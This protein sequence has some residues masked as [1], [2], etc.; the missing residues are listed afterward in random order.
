MPGETQVEVL[1]GSHSQT[2]DVIVKKAI[3]I[4]YIIDELNAYQLM[5]NSGADATAIGK[6]MVEYQWTPTSNMR[7]WR[8]GK[9]FYANQT[10]TGIPYSQ[11][12]N[13]VDKSGFASAMNQPDFYDDYTRFSIIMP[14]YGNDCPGFVSFCWGISRKTTS[15]FVNGI[16][17]GT[18]TKVGTY[19]ADNPTLTSLKTS[20]RNL[21]PGNAVVKSGH[22]FLIASNDRTS[23]VYVY[24]QTPYTAVYTSW[25]YDDL[26]NAG[27]MPF[28]N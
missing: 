7:G 8:D 19:N 26:A 23:K 10:Y 2:I 4:A 6:E 5:A 13:Q 12:A 28:K 1:Y 3:D 27:Y 16:K 18:Y 14:K 20:Y 25:T 11:T 15:D 21:S 17:D 24:E 9:T 22:T